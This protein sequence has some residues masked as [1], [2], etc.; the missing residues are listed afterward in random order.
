VTTKELR[1]QNDA[2]LYK[3][4]QNPP[5][6]L[7]IRKSIGQAAEARPETFD[8]LKFQVQSLISSVY[9]RVSGHYEIFYSPIGRSIEAA[10]NALPSTGERRPPDAENS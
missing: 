9:R 1:Q 5:P 10:L 2:L 8:P 7:L 4:F 3:P 6:G